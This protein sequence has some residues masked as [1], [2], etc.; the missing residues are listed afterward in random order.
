MKLVPGNTKLP[1]VR[2]EGAN[3]DNSMYFLSKVKIME[4]Y[5]EFEIITCI[6]C[7][8]ENRIPSG[9]EGSAR[10]AG[11]NTKIKSEDDYDGYRDIL[12]GLSFLSM[13]F[14][15]LAVPYIVGAFGIVMYDSDANDVSSDDL[16][17]Q[18]GNEETGEAFS[19]ELTILNILALKI[20][21]ISIAIYGIAKMSI[22]VREI[23]SSAAH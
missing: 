8:Q 4:S 3:D 16:G 12:T 22:G 20:I 5:E 18:D 21:H 9:F 11:C 15:L 13:Y 19:I 17:I 2:Y 14:V 10:C 23:Q 1:S 6:V 7:S